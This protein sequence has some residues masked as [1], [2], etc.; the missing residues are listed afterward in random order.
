M[1]SCLVIFVDLTQ[2]L[3]IFSFRSCVVFEISFDFSLYFGLSV[4]KNMR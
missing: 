3:I 1:A 4:S 2:D